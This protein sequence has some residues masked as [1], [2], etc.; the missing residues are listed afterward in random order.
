[1]KKE[2]QRNIGT[3]DG[4]TVGL[5]IIEAQDMGDYCRKLDICIIL[6]KHGGSYRNV[7]WVTK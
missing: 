7:G 2:G 4:D 1:M 6:R 5:A 3:V